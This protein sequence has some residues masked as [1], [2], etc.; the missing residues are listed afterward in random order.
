M[1]FSKFMLVVGVFAA[2]LW[3]STAWAQGPESQQS[4]STGPATQTNPA[5]EPTPN[6][7][8]LSNPAPS[9]QTNPAPET[10]TQPSC[11]PKPGQ[12]ATPDQ[13]PSPVPETSSG[14]PQANPPSTGATNGVAAEQK[15]PEATKK[16]AAHKSGTPGKPRK[17]V[18]RDGG[19][20]EA[21]VQISEGMPGDVAR[22]QRAS[23]DT[24]LS[25]TETNLKR[26]SNRHLT[27]GQQ[28]TVNQ[29]RL[30]MKQ[31]RDAIQKSDV[32][33]AHTLA[34]KAHLLSNSLMK[35]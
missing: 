35:P 2:V 28:D 15:K 27:A 4:Q 10:Q 32:D 18:I 3:V 22:H 1:R 17:R 13:H 24:L 25:S 26:I 9:A 34:L 11:E 19:A 5:T 20:D 33:R 16:S 7:T 14:A 12:G 6:P 29:I 21:E 8:A 30:F 23:T 31:S